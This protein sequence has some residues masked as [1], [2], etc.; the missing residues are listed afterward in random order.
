MS[1]KK[2]ES[3][4]QDLF[5]NVIAFHYLLPKEDFLELILSRLV[6]TFSSSLQN[7]DHWPR[8]NL[9]Y[10]HCFPFPYP[11]WPTAEVP[12]FA[13]E[14]WCWTDPVSEDY[15]HPEAGSRSSLWNCLLRQAIFPVRWYR[16]RF[17]L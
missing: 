11:R 7:L 6:D 16:C 8:S 15:S 1:G 10:T 3:G 14:G 9:G 4:R 5:A 17:P 12:A 2:K 13:P